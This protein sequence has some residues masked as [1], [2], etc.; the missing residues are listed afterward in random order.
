MSKALY[1]PVKESF[2][3]IR[4]LLRQSPA[5]IRLRLLMLIEMKKVGE[6]GITKQQLM[7]RVGVWGQSI[8]TWRK[9]YRTGGIEALLHNGRKG[10]TGRHSV[11]TQ[12]EQDR[13]EEK[14][15]DPNNGLAGYIELQQWVEQEFKKEVKYNTLLKYAGRKFGSKVK[16]ARKSHVKKDAEAVVFFLTLT[17]KFHKPLIISELSFLKMA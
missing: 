12:E 5:M 8:N 3:E 4:K 7:E 1:I 15:K 10:K 11:F 16:A 6:K 13:I 14:L 17:V 9:N 2:E